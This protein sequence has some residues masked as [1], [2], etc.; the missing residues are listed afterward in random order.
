MFYAMRDSTETAKLLFEIAD[1]QQG[2]FTAKQAKEVGYFEESIVYHVKVG[3]WIRE[4]RG[5]Y[6]LSNYPV[7]EH[8]DLMLWYLWSRNRNEEPQG[9]YSHETALALHELSD[10]NPSKLHLTVP[11]GFRRNSKIPD[12]LNLHVADL[13]RSDAQY[14]HG[15]EVTKPMRTILDVAKDET[16]PREFLKQAL[17]QA[18]ARGLIT[19]RELR[20]FHKTDAALAKLAEKIPK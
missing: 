15:V 19:G 7:T 16:I 3:N 6:R 14:M 18:K 4:H 2:F 9:V 5:I 8:S 17:S 10:V 13:S 11:R 20:E 1:A 12:I